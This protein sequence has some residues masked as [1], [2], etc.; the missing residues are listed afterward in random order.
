MSLIR[1][2]RSRED[3]KR[4]YVSAILVISF[5][6]ALITVPNHRIPIL[7]LSLIT[8]WSHITMRKSS[9]HEEEESIIRKIEVIEES[10][11][12]ADVTMPYLT[13]GLDQGSAKYIVEIIKTLVMHQQ[14]LL[15]TLKTYLLLLVKGAICIP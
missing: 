10:N 9:E 4:I 12:I 11:S 2:N 14:Y 15:Q 3:K 8:L 1:K 5:V 7:L 13:H 6:G